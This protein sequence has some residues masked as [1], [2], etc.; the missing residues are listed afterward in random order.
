MR[1]SGLREAK[2]AKSVQKYR[3]SSFTIANIIEIKLK[4]ILCMSYI[5]INIVLQLFIIVYYH[6]WTIQLFITRERE[7]GIF[8]NIFIQMIFFLIEGIRSED[9]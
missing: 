3:I 8:E 2:D 4:L 9:I 7:K 6:Y 1:K 5:V